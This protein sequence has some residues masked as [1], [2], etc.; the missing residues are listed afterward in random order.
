MAVVRA[1]EMGA[2]L[3]SQRTMS[4]L[5]NVPLKLLNAPSKIAI[6]RMVA[7][8]VE[9]FCVSWD[10]PPAAIT[11]DVDNTLD[12]VHG[13]Q[14]LALSNAHYDERR[15]LPIHIYAATSG[16]PVAVILHQGRTAEALDPATR[17]HHSPI[18]ATN[19]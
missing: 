12:S 7:A 11:P 4:Q 10:H 8:V 16:K 2:A 14:Q 17:Q 5:V 19:S 18:G 1:P 3:S 13:H 9:L 6:A 15:F